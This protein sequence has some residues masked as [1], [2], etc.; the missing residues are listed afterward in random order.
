M[1]DL[2]LENSRLRS[3][4]KSLYKDLSDIKDILKEICKEIK[5]IKTEVKTNKPVVSI[6]SVNF[7]GNVDMPSQKKDFS[8]QKN[9]SMFIPTPDPDSL[10]DGIS[11]QIRS[12]KLNKDLLMAAAK[13]RDVKKE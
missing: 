11:K 6:P 3:E 13:L 8:E 10:K 1:Q 12:K 4:N 2:I 9:Q 7:Q 5:E